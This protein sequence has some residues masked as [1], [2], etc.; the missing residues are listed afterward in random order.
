MTVYGIVM[1]RGQSDAV[2]DA[3]RLTQSVA[4]AL[5][6]QL[7]RAMQTVDIAMLGQAERSGQAPN[8]NAGQRTNLLRDVSQ[9]R[10]MLL[11]DASGM[12]TQ[13]TVD[14]LIGLSLGEREWFRVL[15]LSG[16]QMRLGAPE[17]SR[18]LAEPGARPIQDTGQWSIPL[19][20]AIR[21]GRGEFEGA[22]VALLNP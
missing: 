15:R 21:N 22:V 6:D 12:I 3:E 16:Q 2:R 10:A 8:P 17:S 14:G 19:A 1:Y 13:A 9:L 20:R 4:E 18:F 11:T 7:T 5:A